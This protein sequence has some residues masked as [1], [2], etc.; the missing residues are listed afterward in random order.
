MGDKS[1]YHACHG[2]NNKI[3]AIINQILENFPQIQTNLLE[4]LARVSIW[5]NT[6]EDLYSAASALS[7]ATGGSAHA[8]ALVID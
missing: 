4:E 1:I 8:A 5:A 7:Q 2:I 6:I 3:F